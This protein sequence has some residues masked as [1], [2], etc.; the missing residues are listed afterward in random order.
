LSSYEKSE[1]VFEKYY[2]II[3]DVY[4]KNYDPDNPEKF[5]E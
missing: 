2:E 3:N 1:I 5:I 4:D